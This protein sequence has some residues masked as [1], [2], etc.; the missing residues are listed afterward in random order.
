MDISMHDEM[1][2]IM[3]EEFEGLGMECALTPSEGEPQLGDTL[4]VLI[5]VTEQASPAILDL[6]LIQLWDGAYILQ[7]YWTLTLSIGDGRAELEKALPV[8]NF[9]CPIGS[10][11]VFG[12]GEL[13]HKYGLVIREDAEDGAALA[14]DA[15]NA[16]AA[17]YTVLDNYGAAAI[18]IADGSLTLQQAQD[19]GILPVL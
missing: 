10:F 16:V 19:E 2:A 12:E 14:K 4:R 5:A 11:G 18:S 7:L 15:L 6:M 13:Y 17:I 8:I 1:F 3:K 9:F